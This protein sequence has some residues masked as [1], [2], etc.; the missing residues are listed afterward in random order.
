MKKFFSKKLNLVSVVLAVLGLVGILVMLIVP[1][2]TKYTRTTTELEKEV[3]SVYEFKDGKIYSS[4]K[5]DG[6]Y[7]YEDEVIGEYVIDGGKLSYKVP[8]TGLSVELGKINAF[9]YQ[10]NDADDVKYT[11][12]LTVVFFVIAC[13]MTVVGVV[14]VLYGAVINNKKGTKKA[15]AKK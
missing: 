1:H 15:K 9:R 2:G 6:E 7:T 14:G 11:C 8:A 13:V 4:L 10:P 3:T 5:V 12:T